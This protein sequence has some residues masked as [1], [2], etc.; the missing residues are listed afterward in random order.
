MWCG[1][2][3]IDIIVL[4]IKKDRQSICIINPLKCRKVLSNK[5]R[6]CGAAFSDRRRIIRT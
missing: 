2:M 5:L 6:N 4:S 3:Q 1:D